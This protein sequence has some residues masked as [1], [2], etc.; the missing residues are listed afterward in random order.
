MSPAPGPIERLALYFSGEQTRQGILARAALGRAAPGDPEL[1]RRLA[2]GAGDE[3]RPDGSL[4]GAALPTIW[5]ASE[6]LDLGAP[7][8]GEP[9]RR[10][11]QWILQLQ[12]KPGAYGEGCDRER[13]SRRLCEHY[14]EGFFAPASPTER[15]TPITLPNGKVY[16]AEPAARFALSCLALRV[17]LRGGLGDRPGVRRHVHNLASLA[18]RWS[19]WDATFPPDLMAATMQ[20]LAAAGIERRELIARLASLAAANQS[21]DG[22]W[23]AVDFFNALE[24]LL[25]AETEEARGALR[26]A[27]PALIARQRPDGTFG[28]MAQQERALLGLRALLRAEGAR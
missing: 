24:A 27:V 1:A 4:R 9:L 5:R 19:A 18:E 12:G 23:P 20:A 16:R 2:H 7:P 15:L 22:G 13:H 21:P 3:L 28:S 14:L 17:L 8:A 25:A 11:L 10:A 6:L 26:R